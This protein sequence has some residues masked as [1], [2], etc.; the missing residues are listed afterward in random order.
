MR[1][2]GLRA[3]ILRVDTGAR[4]LLS[5]G[6]GNSMADVPKARPKMSFRIGSMAI[7][8]LI[9]LLLQLRDEGRLSLDDRLSDRR[10]F[11]TDRI[12]LRML[13]NNTS[14]YRDWIQGNEAFVHA[15]LGG[16]FRQWTTAELRDRDPRGP[17]CDPGTL[18][19]LRSHQL[20]GPGPGHQHGD[21]TLDPEPRPR[22]DPRAARPA[23]DRDLA[24]TGDA[25]AG[26]PL[27]TAE[28]GFGEHLTE[29]ILTIGDGIV[30]SATRSRTSP[31]PH[32]RSGGAPSPGTSCER[33]A[34]HPDQA[35]TGFSLG[36]DHRRHRRRLQNPR[37]GLATGIMA[38][39]PSRQL[40][41]A[42]VATAK[43]RGAGDERAFASLLFSRLTAYLT[44]GHQPTLG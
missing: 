2:L 4:T 26:P 30:M 24:A 6:L 3:T 18:L 35:Q 5:K 44:P 34:A 10:S 19:Q 7:P 23:P 32:A 39:L 31:A 42:I 11:P 37:P 13:A 22:A 36:R 25:G 12:T 21:G 15:L 8:H 20:R 29:P 33:F 16:V 28:R 9:T 17:A 14:G 38:Y 1:E 43:P 27:S 40:S 41:I